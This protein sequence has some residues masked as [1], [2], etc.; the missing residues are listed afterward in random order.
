MK[1]IVA[2]LL[3][4]GFLSGGLRTISLMNEHANLAAAAYKRGDYTEAVA[5]YEYLLEDLEVRDDQVRLNLG[6]AYFRLGELQK[7]QQQYTLLASH[8][9]RHIKA[10]SLLQLGAIAAK[11]KK[12][13]QALTYFRQVLIVEPENEAARYNYELI[14]KLLEERPDLAQ[15]EE[16]NEQLPANQEGAQEQPMP[17]EPEEKEQV[18]QP[19]KNPDDEGD[20]EAEIDQSEQDDQ[21]QDE[22]QGGAGQEDQPGKENGRQAEKP[23]TS[24]QETG[25]TKGLN[26]ESNFDPDRPERSRSA[27]PLSDAEQRA[28]TRNHR[29]QQHNINPEKARLMLEAM[30]SAEQQYIQ[31]LPK[32][33]TRKPDP[34]KPDW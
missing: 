14:K 2:A 12:Y 29:L 30:R 20:Q 32:K 16:E 13:K 17:Q 10:V 9:T 22:Q 28:Q 1:A 5:S 8:A 27:E 34:S 23:E 25:E 11:G 3:F 24:G 19:R 33:S 6:H 26:P 15:A 4:I 21:G 18:E 7:A 31:Q